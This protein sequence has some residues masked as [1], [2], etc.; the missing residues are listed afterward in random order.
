[1]VLVPVVALSGLAQVDGMM[2]R[3]VGWYDYSEGAF[4]CIVSLRRYHGVFR[5]GG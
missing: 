2:L 3:M 1:M 5:G 4:L